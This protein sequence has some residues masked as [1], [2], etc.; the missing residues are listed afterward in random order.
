[1]IAISGIGTLTPLGDRPDTVFSALLEGRTAV[2]PSST[3]NGVGVTEIRD[4][5]ATNYAKVRGMRMYNR[6]TQLGICAAKLALLDAK[7]EETTIPGEDSGLLMASTYG[8]L[9]VLMEYDRSLVSNGLQRTNAALMPL[10]IPS[11]PGAMVALALGAK[12]FSMTFCDNGASFLDA[13]ALGSRWIEDGRARV[14][15]VVGAFSASADILLAASRAG[16]LAPAEALRIFDRESMGTAFGEGSVAFVLEKHEDA[17]N[18]G[19]KIQGHVRGYGTAFTGKSPSTQSG[20]QLGTLS[21]S[22]VRA[23]T[24]A[25]HSAGACANQLSLI[26]AG[27]SG[28]LKFDRIE[29]QALSS[30]LGEHASRVPITAV[31]GA[32]G[33]TLDASGG[34]QAFVAL[35]SLEKRKTPPI[36]RFKEADIPK[37]KYLTREEQIN[38]GY[39]LITSVAWN[40]ASSALVLSGGDDDCS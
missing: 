13:I 9:D 22:L 1:V 3:Q 2:I 32:L 27:G 39:A 17:K 31:K 14:C 20:A 29:A 4:F 30:L 40:G 25:L 7:I 26:S 38:G 6:T 16:I 37:L 15:V 10:A 23:S 12:A 5:E 35:K 19:A 11:A 34:F 18:R 21:G 24:Q 36:A 33:E 28:L 8:H